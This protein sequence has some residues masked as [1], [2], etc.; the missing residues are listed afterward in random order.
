M[1][2]LVSTKIVLQVMKTI[3]EIFLYET[4]VERLISFELSI[5]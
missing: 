1:Q 2:F 5:P 4:Y 3:A